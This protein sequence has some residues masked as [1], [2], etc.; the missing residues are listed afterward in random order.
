MAT[1]AGGGVET[2][3]TSS[4]SSGMTVFRVMT[5]S[6][7]ILGPGSGCDNASSSGVT[8]T[9]RRGGSLS[10]RDGC[11]AF[12]LFLCFGRGF[13]LSGMGAAGETSQATE[14]GV[15]GANVLIDSEIRYTVDSNLLLRPSRDVT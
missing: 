1:D 9:R 7:S 5:L 4:A 10:L 12:T 8:T 2:T 6:E 11:G 13:G 15:D 14:T 3:G